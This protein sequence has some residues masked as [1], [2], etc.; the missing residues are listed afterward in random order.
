[1]SLRGAIGVMIFVRGR[2]CVYRKSVLSRG[3][4]MSK[5]VMGLCVGAIILMGNSMAYG[6]SPARSIAADVDFRGLCVVTSEVAW[7]SGTKGTYGRTS[8]G[9]HIWMVDH[10]P[11]AE[12]LDFR[13]VKAFGALTACLMS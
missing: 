9:G 10:V 5:R 1:M 13:D 12:K 7:V 6:Q 3:R 11:G 2:Q 4:A 8:D